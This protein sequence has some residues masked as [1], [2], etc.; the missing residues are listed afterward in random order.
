MKH[1]KSLLLLM[2]ILSWSTVPL[3]GKGAFKR[4]LPAAILI[5]IVSK[6]IHLFA[7]KRKWW[8]FVRLNS[9]ISGDTAFVFGPFLVAALWILKFTYNKLF[10]YLITNTIGHILFDIWGLKFLKRSG[11][12]SL[13]RINP[14][15]HFLLLQFRALLLYGIQT[16]LDKMNFFTERHKS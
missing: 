2:V 3:L 14:F 6:V 12:V 9:K 8:K 11:I 7:Q 5:S 10:L 15:Q 16:L 1:S 4:F 13:V